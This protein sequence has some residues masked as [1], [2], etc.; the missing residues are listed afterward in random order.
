MFRIYG[1]DNYSNRK[2]AR[3]TCEERGSYKIASE[4]NKIAWGNK[5][6]EDIDARTKKTN[7]TNLEKYGVDNPMKCEE[8]KET[9][10]N[11][12]KREYRKNN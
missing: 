2:K 5:T 12:K 11:K 3:Q 8:V 4:K 7:I 6:Q 1:K 9:L 10:K